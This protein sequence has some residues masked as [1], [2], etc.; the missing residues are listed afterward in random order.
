MFFILTLSLVLL[1]TFSTFPMIEVAAQEG[2]QRK[3]KKVGAMT[4]KVAKKLSAAQEL[5]EDENLEEGLQELN[6]IMAFKKLTDYE[7][8]QV[9][10]FYGY[11]EYLKENYEG[12]I[13]YYRKVLQDEKV[14]E[15][16]VSSARTT[17]AQLYFQLEDYPKTIAAVDEIL[18]NQ[19]TPRP[20]LYVLKGT[21]QYQLEQYEKAIESV[22]QAISVA[23]SRN[24]D[25]VAQLQKNVTSA[26]GKYRVK[27]DRNNVDH[28]SLANEVKKVL[29][30]ELEETRKGN[31]KYIQL[32]EEIK[33]HEAD[34]KNLAIGSNG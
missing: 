34:A 10:Y 13:A 25:R 28:I 3:T 18:K 15:G 26:A 16:L 21:A 4:E 8:A 5:I 20:D 19:T 30:L 11:V 33:G 17:I 29:K 22:E 24:A 23:E 7:R 9:N 31:E 32:E 6:D 27:Y 2:E 12:A 14:P 1:P